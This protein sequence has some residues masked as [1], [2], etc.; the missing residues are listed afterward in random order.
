MVNQ[1]KLMPTDK[2]ILTFIIRELENK[3]KPEQIMDFLISQ[4]L[5]FK[6]K[7]YK[8]QFIKRTTYFINLAIEIIID[9]YVPL[10]QK[11]TESNNILKLS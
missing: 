8:H 10:A 2:I 11:L 1:F 5:P 9:K 6:D 4:N 7:N 3:Q